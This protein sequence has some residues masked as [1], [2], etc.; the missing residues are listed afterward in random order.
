MQGVIKSFSRSNGYGFL[1]T[2]KGDIFFHI[3]NCKCRPEHGKEVEFDI[4]E[5]PKGLRA[6]N[7]KGVKNE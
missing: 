6:I 2:D 1:D 4:V 7:V 3:E 5:S